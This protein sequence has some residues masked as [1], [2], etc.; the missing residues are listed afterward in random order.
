LLRQTF[1]AVVEYDGTELHGFQRQPHVRTVAGELEA[2]LFRIF[3]EP[4][5]VTGAGRTDVG[6]HAVAQVVSFTVR[7][8][9]RPEKLALALN[10]NIASDVSVRAVVPVLEGFSA[11]F[12]A[13]ERRYLYQVLNRPERSA[14]LRRF[15][16]H[17]HRRLDMAALRRA[18]RDCTGEHD[19]RAFCG[20][21][22]ENGNTVRTVYSVD[23]EEDDPFLRL[24]FRARGFLHH[25]VRV[26]TGT[27]LDIAAGRLPPDG[28]VRML[29]GSERCL[30]ARTAPPEGLFFLGARYPDFDSNP[31]DVFHFLR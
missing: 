25:M 22:P 14:V 30:A 29:A 26:M 5:S 6:V 15:A 21:L 23:V 28:V 9:F 2:A 27:L 8:V 16:H 7:R 3:R 18:A 11:R 12:D 20:V 17:D 1:R 13:L 31:S 10:G 24:R 4:I 19:F